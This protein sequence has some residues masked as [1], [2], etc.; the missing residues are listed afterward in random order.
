MSACYIAMDKLLV[1]NLCK[2]QL[3]II[4]KIDKLLNRLKLYN[5]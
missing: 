4:I 5:R 3:D 1:S 2:F